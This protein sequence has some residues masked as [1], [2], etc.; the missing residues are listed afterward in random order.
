[1]FEV[2]L[3]KVCRNADTK[4]MVFGREEWP[5]YG[6]PGDQFMVHKLCNEGTVRRLWRM[7]LDFPNTQF[8]ERLVKLTLKWFECDR[9]TVRATAFPKG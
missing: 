9:L 7:F 6:G 3:E 1:M 8:D 2:V 5:V 4:T